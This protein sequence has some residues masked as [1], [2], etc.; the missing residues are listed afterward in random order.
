[1]LEFI[2]RYGNLILWIIT[3]IGAI[4]GTI[5]ASRDTYRTYGTIW[6]KVT[7]IIVTVILVAILGAVL[8]TL[9]LITIQSMLN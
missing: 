2:T 9:I 3:I 8:G 6:E 4:T 7:H 5:L 1:M